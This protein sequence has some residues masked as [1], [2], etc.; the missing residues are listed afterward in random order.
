[1]SEI[2]EAVA[3]LREAGYLV[4]KIPPCGK[5][6]SDHGRH[7]LIT[8]SAACEGGGTIP[9]G[10]HSSHFGTFGKWMNCQCGHSF[11]DYGDPPTDWEKHKAEHGIEA[12]S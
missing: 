5:E 8:R 11:S 2:D 10:Y 1:M 6:G 9:H 12:Q 3:L 4:V 7:V